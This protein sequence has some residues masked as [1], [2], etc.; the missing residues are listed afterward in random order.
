M[1][2]SDWSSDVCSSDLVLGLGDLA[3]DVLHHVVDFSPGRAAVGLRAGEVAH[4]RLPLPRSE[5]DEQLWP[6]GRG[7]ASRDDTERG[8]DEALRAE[9][10]ELGQSDP[11][12]AP[13]NEERARDYHKS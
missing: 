7:L 9:A 11:R 12:Q 3:D 8:A 10:H 2:I 13:R 5:S 6:L 1:R 4:D